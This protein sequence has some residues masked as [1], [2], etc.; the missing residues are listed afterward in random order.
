MARFISDNDA[1]YSTNNRIHIGTLKLIMA[2]IIIL[3]LILIILLILMVWI[4]IIV[5]NPD[6][7]SDIVDTN[8]DAEVN[9][10]YNATE[11]YVA[12]FTCFDFNDD[13]YGNINVYAD[14]ETDDDTVHDS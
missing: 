5:Q 11:V 8:D 2:L 9:D 7:D 4:L 14:N 12:N 3:M 13:T 10:D 1:D 6:V